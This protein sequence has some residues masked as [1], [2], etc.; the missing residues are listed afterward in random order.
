MDRFD[1]ERGRRNLAAAYR[2]RRWPAAV[3][4]GLL[5]GGLGLLYWR[6]A[7]TPTP[8]REAPVS[9]PVVA[10]DAGTPPLAALGPAEQT[11]PLVRDILGRLFQERAIEHWLKSGDLIRRF[12]AAVNAVA[13]GE[14]PRPSLP[15]LAPEGPF[16]IKRTGGRTVIDERSYQRYGPFVQA[17]RA[18]DPA[19]CAAAYA[20][21]SPLLESAHAE[22]GRPGTTFASALGKAIGRLVR[23]P[24]PDG[25]LAVDSPKVLYQY[26]DPSLE[27]RPAAE[28]QLLRLGPE[29]ARAL[30]E[31][32]AAI[33]SALKLSE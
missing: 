5:A 22:I 30:Q 28:K 29:N 20:R 32:L 18:L 14:S 26:A 19:A 33:A 6:V 27:S 25:P 7:S 9:E 21:L 8:V 4:A 2:P 31:K 16:A 23:V 13:D 24:V 12:V 15:F 17:V 10:A 3:A 11:D 1:P